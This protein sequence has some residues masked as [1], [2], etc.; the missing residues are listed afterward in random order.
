MKRFQSLVFTIGTTAAMICILALVWAFVFRE[1]S[2]R[3]LYAEY[4]VYRALTALT[5]MYRDPGAVMPPDERILGFGLYRSDGTLL[6][7]YGRAPERLSPEILQDPASARRF[8]DSSFILVRPF[9]MDPMRRPVPGRPDRPGGGMMMPLGGAARFAYIEYGLGSFRREQ[10]VLIAGALAITA[11]LG[12]AYALLIHLYGRNLDLRDREYQNRELVQLG[13]AARTLAHEIKNP[14]GIIRVQSA[15]LAR[16]VGSGFEEGFRIIDEE[17]RRLGALVDRI[18]DFLKSGEG[19]PESVEL[20]E[21]LEGWARRYG[22]KVRLEDPVPEGTTVRI[23][24]GR[25]TDI[26]DNL[27]RNALES[28]EE[29]ADETP[30]EVLGSVKRGQAVVAVQD[31]GPGVDPGDEPRLFEPFFT[32]KETGT[33]IGLALSSKWARTAGGTL[34]YRPREGGGAVFELRLPLLK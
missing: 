13:Q 24:R 20:R 27:A 15:L 6:Y 1:R 29:R 32:T 11:A 12:A 28:M 17:I 3:R 19:R 9:G 26:L 21:F 4:E 14:L 18:R 5:D 30:V 34:S 8:T 33:G 22:G 16:T 7:Q 2:T 23:D 31:R 10:R 25:L